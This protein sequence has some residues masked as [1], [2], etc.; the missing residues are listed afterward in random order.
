MSSSMMESSVVGGEQGDV[1]QQGDLVEAQ[2]QVD[3]PFKSMLEKYYQVLAS[4][5][6]IFSG[7]EAEVVIVNEA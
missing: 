2:D 4:H 1:V 6:C 3:Q 5:H 7:C